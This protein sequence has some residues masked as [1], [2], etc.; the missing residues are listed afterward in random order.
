METHY[1]SRIGVAIG[2]IAVGAIILLHNLHLFHFGYHYWAWFLLIPISVLVGDILN[3]K[4]MNDGKYPHDVTGQII[5]V[6]A[7]SSVLAIFVFDLSFHSI[8]PV[9]IILAGVAVLLGR[10]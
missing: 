1:N 9:F 7:M 3:R 6:F 5:G 2:F 10:R 8:W 4:R